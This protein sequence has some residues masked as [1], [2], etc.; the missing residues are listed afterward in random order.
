MRGKVLGFIPPSGLADIGARAS[1]LVL[2]IGFGMACFVLLEKPLERL[3]KGGAAPK[4]GVLDRARA[5][6]RR[7]GPVRS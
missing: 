6:F 2:C 4:I 3:L 7:L 5:R 1:G